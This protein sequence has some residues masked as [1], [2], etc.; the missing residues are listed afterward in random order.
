MVEWLEQLGVGAGSC[1]TVVS[2]RLGFAMRRIEHSL[3]QPSGKWVPFS[4]WATIRQR[5]LRDGLRL[6]LVV[7][8]IWETFTFFTL[9]CEKELA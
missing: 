9:Q 5:K 6:S 4:N 8:K 7:P 3:C 2:S 1:L